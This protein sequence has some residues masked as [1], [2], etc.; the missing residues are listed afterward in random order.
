[1]WKR[2]LNLVGSRFSPTVIFII[3]DFEFL[4][5]KSKIYSFIYLFTYLIQVTI[6]YRNAALESKMMDNL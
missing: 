5:F 2:S 4:V 3:K 1:M 6:C